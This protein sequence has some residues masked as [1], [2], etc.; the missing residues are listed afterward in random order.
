[1]PWPTN[2][3]LEIYYKEIT[4]NVHENVTTRIFIEYLQEKVH[5]WSKWSRIGD[6]FI[7]IHSYMGYECSHTNWKKKVIRLHD[8]NFFS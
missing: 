7:A 5:I 2:F 8:P 1:M 3:F 6:Q 4:I